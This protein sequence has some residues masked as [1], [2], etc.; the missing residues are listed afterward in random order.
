[1]GTVIISTILFIIVTLIVKSIC[2]KHIEAKKNGSVCCGCAKC[3]C[4]CNKND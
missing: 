3:S 1:M 2:K 4:G